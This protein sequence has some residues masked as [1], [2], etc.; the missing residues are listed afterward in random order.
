MIHKMEQQEQVNIRVEDSKMETIKEMMHD[1]RERMDALMDVK[2]QLDKKI[3]HF[4]GLIL[5]VLSA[6]AGFGIKPVLFFIAN[7]MYMPSVL[8]MVCFVS[9]FVLMCFLVVALLPK[10]TYVKGIGPSLYWENDGLTSDTKKTMI[11]ISSRYQ[12]MN[13]HQAQVIARK[14]HILKRCMICF[15][16]ILIFVMTSFFLFPSV[17]RDLLRALNT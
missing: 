17:A 13:N 4:L 8:F 3:S 11:H 1:V 15:G 5:V 14:G 12:E 7:K 6:V 10:R 2:E 9:M 16:I